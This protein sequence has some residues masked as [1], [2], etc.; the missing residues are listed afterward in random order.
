MRMHLVTFHHKISTVRVSLNERLFCALGWNQFVYEQYSERK[1][2][3]LDKGVAREMRKWIWEILCW[4]LPCADKWFIARTSNR[5]QLLLRLLL[6]FYCCYEIVNLIFN[7][8]TDR[9]IVNSILSAT[10]LFL[11]LRPPSTHKYTHPSKFVF[12][13]SIFFSCRSNDLDK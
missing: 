11:A 6:W 3:T 4:H 8:Q 1:A 13:K 12:I 7:R 5:N 10:A 9:H 2:E